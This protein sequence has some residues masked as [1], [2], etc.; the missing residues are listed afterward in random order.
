MP[1]DK[2]GVLLKVNDIVTV[3]C[4]I[5]GIS[6]SEDYCNLSLMTVEQMPPTNDRSY[7]SLNAKQVVKAPE[8][9]QQGMH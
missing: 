7:L 5:T 2:N 6:P 9:Q 8:A 1:H 3:S 4:V